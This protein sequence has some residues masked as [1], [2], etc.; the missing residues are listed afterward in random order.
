M[1]QGSETGE[2]AAMKTIMDKEFEFITPCFCAGA[3]QN[4]PEIR[5]STI[6]G[7]LRWW[8]RVLSGSREEEA[9]TFGAVHGK[10]NPSAVVVRVNDVNVKTAKK[11]E[12][13]PMSDKGYLYF[14]AEKSGNDKGIHR[15]AP[16]HY[17]AP[18]T[19]FR[20]QVL[21]RKEISEQSAVL[22][23]RSLEMFLVFGAIG[24]RATR[25]CGAFSEKD[26]V[27]IEELR[28]LA[29]MDPKILVRKIPGTETATS[30]EKCQESLGGFLRDLR[31]NNRLS[32]KIESA[33]GYSIGTRR[34]SSALR[35]RPVKTANGFLPVIIYT[36]AACSQP[37]ISDMVFRE[38]IKI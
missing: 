29:R 25:G 9:E 7:E 12:F 38:T 5:A 16:G 33:L 28:K 14:F 21:L 27:D 31:K 15:T 2:D 6:R 22:L 17:L 30:G 4:K 19:S 13:R 24:L 35:L 34:M 37:S 26:G 20:L 36:D 32:G 3:D 18:G 1:V 23:N 10:A 11:I 8:F